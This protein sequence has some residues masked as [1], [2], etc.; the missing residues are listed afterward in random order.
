MIAGRATP[1]RCPCSMGSNGEQ[2]VPMASTTLGSE[3]RSGVGALSTRP[4]IAPS[5]TLTRASLIVEPADVDSEK[6]H[7]LAHSAG[8]HPPL[9]RCPPDVGPMTDRRNLR[10]AACHRSP[11]P[12]R[13]WRPVPGTLRH[14]GLVQ[15]WRPA[16]QCHCNFPH[17]WR[18]KI[19]HYCGSPVQATGFSAAPCFDGRPRRLGSAGPWEV[20]LV[21]E[22]AC[23]GRRSAWRRSR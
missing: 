22:R 11:A 16:C 3:G 6:L 9:A 10:L 4:A 14:I 19:P 20:M 15:A 8:R 21:T 5:A 13:S 23:S 18:S 7:G 1:I 12:R 2:S 17:K